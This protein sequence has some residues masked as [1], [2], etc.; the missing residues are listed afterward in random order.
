MV[1]VKSNRRGSFKIWGMSEE[2]PSQSLL[3]T[4]LDPLLK[5]TLRS[6]LGLITLTIL[7]TVKQIIFFQ[8]NKFVRLKME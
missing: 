3:V 1:K 2:S 4:N 7:K 8:S 5:Y 6:V